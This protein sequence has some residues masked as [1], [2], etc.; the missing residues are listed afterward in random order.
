MEK[1]WSTFFFNNHLSI[2]LNNVGQQSFLQNSFIGL[3]SRQLL[4]FVLNPCSLPL[5]SPW[6]VTGTQQYMVP[7]GLKGRK[8]CTGVSLNLKKDIL[9]N[10][11]KQLIIVMT[12]VVQIWADEEQS[13]RKTFCYKHINTHTCTYLLIHMYIYMWFL[14]HV[15][16]LLIKRN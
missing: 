16:L 12:L 14:N 9:M 15:N 4:V 11:N 2:I 3:S 10:I 8:I 1:I 6:Q 13:W 7:F 5:S